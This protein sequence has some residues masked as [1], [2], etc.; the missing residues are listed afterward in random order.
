MGS[1]FVKIS[2]VFIVISILLIGISFS[3]VDSSKVD[4]VLGQSD[5]ALGQDGD[6]NEASQSESSSQ[7]A[8]Q[9]SM[10]VS[11]DSTSLSCN[12]LSAENDNVIQEDTRSISGKIYVI[13][14]PIVKSVSGK[15]SSTANCNPGDS[16]V[17]GFL[18]A[19]ADPESTNTQDIPI[20][21]ISENLDPESNEYTIQWRTLSNERPFILTG[22]AVCFDNP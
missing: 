3:L 21:S 18:S 8:N 19:S 15:A 16:I 10:C 7:S 9:N 2:F 22:H 1:L 6:G 14:G 13:D 5:N 12:N 4:L 11:G 17:S 20:R